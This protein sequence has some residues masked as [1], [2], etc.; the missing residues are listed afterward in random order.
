MLFRC[1]PAPFASPPVP[2][3]VDHRTAPAG[4]YATFLLI[5]MLAVAARHRDT[6][7]GV[8][9]ADVGAAPAAAGAAAPAAAPGLK[10]PKIRVKRGRVTV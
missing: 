2:G 1:T 7:G 9:P 3:P 10:S 6:G 8:R 5:M 4:Q